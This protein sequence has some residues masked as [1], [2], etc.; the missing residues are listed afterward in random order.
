MFLEFIRLAERIRRQAAGHAVF[1]MPNPGNWGDA[2]IRAGTLRLFA[3]YGISVTEINRMSLRFDKARWLCRA[4]LGKSLLLFGGGGAWKKDG[5]RQSLIAK[6]SPFFTSVIVLPST[7]EQQFAQRKVVYFRRDNG[8]SKAHMP[9]ATFCHDL[10]FY[11]GPLAARGRGEG[12]GRFFR[13]DRE[14]AGKRLLP[15]DNVDISTE[16]TDLTEVYPFFARIAKFSVLHTDRLHVAIGG[17][18]LQREVHLYS[19]SYFKN[20]AVYEASMKDR[21][22][23]VH[24]HDSSAA[25]ERN[26]SLGSA[27]DG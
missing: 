20:R 22:A 4:K 27:A 19:N 23:N 24:F 6:Y 9:D 13:T 11:L 21:F 14:S 5:S 15:A 17:C 16:G 7:Y 12:V 1:Y 25:A 26:V 18:L 10:A 3:D 2:L 8:G